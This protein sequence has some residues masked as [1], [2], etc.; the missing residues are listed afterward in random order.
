ME[1][2]SLIP[3]SRAALCI[4]PSDQRNPNSPRRLR[5]VETP[6]PVDREAKLRAIGGGWIPPTPTLDKAL[7]AIG[8][9]Y[10]FADHIEFARE[11]GRIKGEEGWARTI[12]AAHGVTP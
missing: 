5:V 10:G 12:L 11:I 2:M 3:L 7:E 4:W 8:E 6:L 9:Q 1:R